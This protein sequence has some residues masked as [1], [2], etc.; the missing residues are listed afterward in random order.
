SKRL[1]DTLRPIILLT[2][3]PKMPGRLF[4]RMMRVVKADTVNDRG[5]RRVLPENVGLLGQFGFNAAAQLANTLFVSPATTV[6]RTGGTV[7]AD[8]PALLPSVSIA[9]PAGATHFQFNLGA[10]LVDF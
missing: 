9:A 10:S 5:L 8:I 1:R 7:S 2:Y 6:D 4:S 3:D